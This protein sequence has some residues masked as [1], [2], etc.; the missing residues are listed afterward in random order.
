M[1]VSRGVQTPPRGDDGSL[2]GVGLTP[3]QMI[4][5][6]VCPPSVEAACALLLCAFS[7][8]ISL[9]VVGGRDASS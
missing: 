3:P 5:T 4:V 7:P 6:S 2:K 9:C 8:V 1:E